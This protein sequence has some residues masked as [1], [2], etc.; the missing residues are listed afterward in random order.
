M[1][2]T[3]LLSAA[4][5]AAA[6]FASTSSIGNVGRRCRLT[7]QVAFVLR[8]VDRQHAKDYEIAIHAS[9]CPV[10]GNDRA[11]RINT[12]NRE[13]LIPRSRFIDASFL[14]LFNQRA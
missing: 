9:H 8:L 2:I 10:R 7:E 14:E 11:Q 12:A 13:F 3:P 6:S 1:S 4:Q 5:A